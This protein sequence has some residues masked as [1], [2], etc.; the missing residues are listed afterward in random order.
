MYYIESNNLPI[1]RDDGSVITFPSIR[2]ARE[3]VI[4]HLDLS[5]TIHINPIQDFYKWKVKE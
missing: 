1:L 3:W 5:E 2:E 4:G